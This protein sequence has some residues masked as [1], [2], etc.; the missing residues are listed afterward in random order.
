MGETEH[1]SC[2]EPDP[3]DLEALIYLHI[4]RLEKSDKAKDVRTRREKRLIP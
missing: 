1:D 3:S 4:V 2:E